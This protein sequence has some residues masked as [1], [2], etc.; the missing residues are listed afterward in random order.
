MLLLLSPRKLK[1]L[2]RGPHLGGLLDNE[3]YWS[4][5]KALNP[6]RF[7]A[8]VFIFKQERLISSH[9][10]STPVLLKHSSFPEGTKSLKYD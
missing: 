1:T 4:D 10:P 9:I 5:E 8:F 6:W 7:K 3:P 2:S